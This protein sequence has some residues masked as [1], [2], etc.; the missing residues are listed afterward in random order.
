MILGERKDNTKALNFTEYVLIFHWGFLLFLIFYAFIEDIVGWLMGTESLKAQ[1][2]NMS[3]L[4]IMCMEI[5]MIFIIG[6]FEGVCVISFEKQKWNDMCWYWI[7]CFF[8]L[9]FS[10]FTIM[11]TYRIWESVFKRVAWESTKQSFLIAGSI[12]AREFIGVCI[13]CIL[14][15]GGIMIKTYS[16]KKNENKIY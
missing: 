10:Y 2:Y 14:G 4:L 12:T 16:G 6:I 13:G 8:V 15:K 5:F 1:P 7:I 9:W 11:E 3:G